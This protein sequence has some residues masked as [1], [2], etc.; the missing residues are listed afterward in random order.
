MSEARPLGHADQAERATGAFRLRFKADAVIRDGKAK[1][2]ILHCQFDSRRGSAAVLNDVVQRLL[3]DSVETKRCVLRHR[4]RHGAIG[5][6]YSYLVS[7]R[8]LLAE[9][10]HR[11]DKAELLQFGRM[12]LVRKPVNFRRQSLHLGREFLHPRADLPALPRRTL[13]EHLQLNRKQG[14]ALTQIIVQFAGESRL[15]LFL[16]LD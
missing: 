13:A 9:S 10:A 4:S 16:G 14:E 1:V 5:K 12:E 8:E 11:C 7:S 2:A 15:L 6:L 3:R